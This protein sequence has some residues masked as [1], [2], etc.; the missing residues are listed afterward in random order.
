[1]SPSTSSPDHV[2]N[3]ITDMN[4]AQLVA[5]R[6]LAGAARWQ[7]DGQWFGLVDPSY[8]ADLLSAQT[9]VS[10][11]FVADQPTIA[12]M[13]PSQRFGF[14]LLEDNSDGLLTLGTSGADCGLFFHKNFMHLVMGTPEF[15][16]SD[17]HSNK[18]HGYLISVHVVCGAALGVAGNK[19]HIRV[20]N[21]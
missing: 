1:V 21:T 10:T 5:I 16:V 6:K 11:D 7:K 12:G 18:Q 13:I 4:A 19:K 8:W 14:K 9:L 2:L 17:L 15:K 20:Y 3:G